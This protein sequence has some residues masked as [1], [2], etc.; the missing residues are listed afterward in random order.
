MTET[1][2]N[3]IQN[4]PPIDLQSGYHVLHTW[5]Q[6]RPGVLV[7]EHIKHNPMINEPWI[8]ELGLDDWQDGAK[9][10]VEMGRVHAGVA[11]V[12]IAYDKV[13]ACIRAIKVISPNNTRKVKNY[14]QYGEARANVVLES[15]LNA[16]R[17]YDN[18]IDPNGM[19]YIVF[20]HLPRSKY[21]SLS[22]I[23][24]VA[25]QLSISDIVYVIETVASVIDSAASKGIFHNDIALQNIMVGRQG[26]ISKTP[27]K[28]IDFGA[29]NLACTSINAGT[30][31][32]MSP[33]RNDNQDY[34][35]RSEVWSLAV[36][37]H[38]LL[39][40]K[41]PFEV[42]LYNVLSG[43]IKSDIAF[44]SEYSSINTDEAR[45]VLMKALSIDP[46]GRYSTATEF[47]GALKRALEFPAQTA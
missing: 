13:L 26:D 19:E 29:S 22:E 25:R 38:K 32:T 24:Q 9:Y 45:S 6:S 47:A 14:I 7:R 5:S 10:I 34:D 16:I 23:D 28:V 46:P 31:T 39:T 44:M 11:R 35:V 20:E 21:Q 37:A 27:L 33:E 17:V 12:I 41:Y 15:H 43:N 40:G 8:E 4:E 42:T 1:A 18:W 2:E 36:V 30:P 3:P